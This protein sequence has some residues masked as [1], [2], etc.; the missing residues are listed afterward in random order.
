M[1]DEAS[2]LLAMEYV[3]TYSPLAPQQFGRRDP[4][5]PA[6]FDEWILSPSTDTFEEWCEQGSS[7]GGGSWSPATS[8]TYVAPAPFLYTP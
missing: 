7:G 1:G 2:L 4:T 5:D 8:L 3:T 6:C